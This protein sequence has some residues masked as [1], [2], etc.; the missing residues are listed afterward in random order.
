[1][2]QETGPTVREARRIM[3]QSW[4]TAGSTFPACA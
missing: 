2:L 1:M 4:S 3:E